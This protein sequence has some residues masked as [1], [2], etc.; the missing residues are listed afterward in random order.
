MLLTLAY[1]SRLKETMIAADLE[2]AGGNGSRVTI[3]QVIS[4]AV[5]RSLLTMHM[6]ACNCDCG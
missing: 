4:L 6:Y 5:L 2:T 1:S 3:V